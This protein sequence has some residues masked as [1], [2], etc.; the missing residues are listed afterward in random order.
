MENGSI[1]V[2][3]WKPRHRSRS[4][5]DLLHDAQVLPQPSFSICMRIVIVAVSCLGVVAGVALLYIALFLTEPE[6]ES[7]QNRLEDWWLRIK[8]H[9][10]KSQSKLTVFMREIARLSSAG[11]DHVFGKKLISTQSIV[12]SA[13]YSL[14]SIL[15]LGFLLTIHS[16]SPDSAS[17]IAG[18]VAFLLIA[19]ALVFFATRYAKVAGGCFIFIIV[20]SIAILYSVGSTLVSE[21]GPI[22]VLKVTG[23]L[24]AI[25]FPI[26]SDTFFYRDYSS[27]PAMGRRHGFIRE[28]HLYY[29]CK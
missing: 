9:Q 25:L 19:I 13:S 5:T 3:N 26:A 2:V 17:T 7:I 6:E 4:P 20:F 24:I 10:Q 27:S 21:D 22:G 23:F 14:A 15:L 28:D 1:A 29:H 8:E 16:K 11:L 18:S 12:V